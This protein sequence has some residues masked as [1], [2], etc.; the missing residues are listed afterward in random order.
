VGE[1]AASTQDRHC[2]FKDRYSPAYKRLRQ[3]PGI[4]PVIAAS[5]VGLVGSAE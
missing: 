2:K 1:R 4:G 3:I 5:L